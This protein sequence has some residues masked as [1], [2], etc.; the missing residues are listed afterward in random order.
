MKTI[1]YSVVL[2][3]IGACITHIAIILLIPSYASKDAWAQLSNTAGKWSFNVV[4]RPEQP[5]QTLA[6]L[7]PALGVAACLFNLS[8]APLRVVAGGDLPFWSVAVFD[9]RGQ[10]I[11]SFN[12]R[13]A[14]ER[15]SVM[16]V[17]NPTQ[18]ARLRKTP[19]EELEQAVVIE[20]DTVEGFVLLRAL[21]TDESWAPRIDNF[22]KEASCEKF[23]MPE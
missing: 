23:E 4:A 12:D 20:A 21:Q 1:I 3:L 19:V 14:I 6:K 11:Y 13:T 9:K 2:T 7:D 17:V 8:E 5:E 10:N 22:L 16:V 15:E 18:R